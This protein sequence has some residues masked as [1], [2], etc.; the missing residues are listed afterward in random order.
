[1]SEL[2]THAIKIFDDTLE[3]LTGSESVGNA[4]KKQQLA[5]GYI[6]GLR[7][8]GL[9]TDKQYSAMDTLLRAAKR[10]YPKT[11]AKMQGSEKEKTGF[12]R[13]TKGE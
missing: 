3:D 5:Q 8:L 7:L 1:M 10:K 9:I 6:V 11:G 2:M 12:S 4:Q 13:N